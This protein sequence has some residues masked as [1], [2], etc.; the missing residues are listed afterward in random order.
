MPEPLARPVGQHGAVREV[1][2]ADAKG[3]VAGGRHLRRGGRGRDR[4]RRDRRRRCRRAP[5]PAWGRRTG[6]LPP[7]RRLNRRGRWP[8]T[9]RI[10]VGV[11]IPRH[12]LELPP[13]DPAGGVDLLGGQLGGQLH[14]HPIGSLNEPATPIRTGLPSAPATPRAERRGAKR[15]S[16]AQLAGDRREGPRWLHG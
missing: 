15:R 8:R 7:R 16:A 11:V 1:A 13:V 6:A 5:Q 4:R 9:P 14:R 12:D 3:V 2:G 10:G